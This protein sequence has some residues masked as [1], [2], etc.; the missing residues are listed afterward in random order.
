M[1]MDSI[2]HD[3]GHWI[4]SFLSY[5]LLSTWAFWFL[6]PGCIGAS[7]PTICWC[8]H[9][10]AMSLTQWNEWSVLSSLNLGGLGKGTPVGDCKTWVRTSNCAVMCNPY[11]E[12]WS[13][14][15]DRYCKAPWKQAWLKGMQEVACLPFL[16]IDHA[17]MALS[18]LGCFPAKWPSYTP[19]SYTHLTLPTKA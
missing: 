18:L 14:Y 17:G 1:V 6:L 15:L 16:H 11:C 2:N 8:S 9:V 12:K 4:F 3:T 10:H 7:P 5:Q 19:V 13:C